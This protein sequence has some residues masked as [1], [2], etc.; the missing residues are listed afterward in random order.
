LQDGL[1]VVQFAVPSSATGAVA[2]ASSSRSIV[3]N[4]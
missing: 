3:R 1:I 4:S 2:A